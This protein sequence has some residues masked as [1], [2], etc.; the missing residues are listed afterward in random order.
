ML[1]PPRA[2]LPAPSAAYAAGVSPQVHPY[3]PQVPSAAACTATC[4]TRRRSAPVLHAE[5]RLKLLADGYAEGVRPQVA[6]DDGDEPEERRLARVPKRSAPP[7]PTA[8]EAAAYRA[9]RARTPTP[10]PPPSP[11]HAAVAAGCTR[12]SWWGRFERAAER[13]AEAEGLRLLRSDKSP[14][15]FKGVRLRDDGRFAAW[16]SA[17]EMIG[18]FASPALAAL[19]IAR[20]LRRE[21]AGARPAAPPPAEAAEA[22]AAAPAQPQRQQQSPRAWR[23]LR[24]RDKPLLARQ[25]RPAV[26]AA[27]ARCPS[28]QPRPPGQG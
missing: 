24:R 2:E 9:R 25:R 22:A 14:T 1:H 18:T 13:A 17:T 8:E 12:S 11:P 10:P 7:E 19:A 27:R 3:Q 20:R 5:V 4:A 23:L 21:V 15:G 28:P 6:D 26:Q 16:C